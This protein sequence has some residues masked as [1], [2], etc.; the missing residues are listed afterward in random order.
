M[1]FQG[2]NASISLA[3]Q[4]AA[5]R[6]SICDNHASGSTSFIL[7]VWMRVESVAQVLPPPA[8]PAN[9]LFFR[10]I[11]WGRM[12]RSTMLEFDPPVVEEV[13]EGF[14]PTKGIANGLGEF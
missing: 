6:S 7:A 10:T 13:F 5:M 9:G 11:A 8:F 2:I 12:A 3:G 1:K 4:P 14:T